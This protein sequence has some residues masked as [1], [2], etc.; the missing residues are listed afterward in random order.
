MPEELDS[1]NYDFTSVVAR[2][3]GIAVE[4]AVYD[5]CFPE[6]PLLREQFSHG[7]TNPAVVVSERP[8]LIAVATGLGNTQ[9]G[10]Y[11]PVVKI[12]P[13]PLD[14]MTG[15]PPKIGLKLATIALYERGPAVDR[16]ETFDPIVVNCVTSNEE[17]IQ[18][19]FDSIEPEAWENLDKDLKLIPNEYKAGCQFSINREDGT[20]KYMGH[21]K[22]SLLIQSI[23]GAALAIAYF[24]FCDSNGRALMH[25]LLPDLIK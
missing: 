11:Y 16:W 13:Q 15:G 23:I 10:P 14:K 2:P 8:Y 7:C 9:D 24:L 6:R 19:V 1:S 22:R 4:Q 12:V 5:R 21:P 25:Q 20:A 18:R 17:D 3:G